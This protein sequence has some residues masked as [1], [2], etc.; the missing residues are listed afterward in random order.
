MFPALASTVVLLRPC[1]LNKKL[2]ALLLN[3]L[4]VFSSLSRGVLR[5]FRLFVVR[6]SSL[7]SFLL[8]RFIQW[9]LNDPEFAVQTLYRRR[10]LIDWAKVRETTKSQIIQGL[11]QVAVMMSVRV[12]F[13]FANP[14]IVLIKHYKGV[15]RS[16]VRSGP[17]RFDR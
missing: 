8:Q 17:S 2:T 14:G 13:A 1:I 10:V 12:H 11:W 7:I 4:L 15:L 3:L 16:Q 5:D 9:Y 6:R